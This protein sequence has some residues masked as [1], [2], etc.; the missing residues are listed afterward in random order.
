MLREPPRTELHPN[1]AN[2]HDA[3]CS[4][5]HTRKKT[6]QTATT[7]SSRG[8]DR[9]SLLTDETPTVK[10]H[11][12]FARAFQM[13]GHTRGRLELQPTSSLSTHAPHT[14]HGKTHDKNS[15]SNGAKFV[16]QRETQRV[17][18]VQ[19]CAKMMMEKLPKRDG[20]DCPP[21]RNATAHLRAHLLHWPGETPLP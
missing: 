12:S 11:H 16:W 2:N 19:P 8:M 7:A 10:R 14:A 3:R 17:S 1:H 21:E 5:P 15:Q 20:R 6:R 4:R 9:I 13:K 18:I